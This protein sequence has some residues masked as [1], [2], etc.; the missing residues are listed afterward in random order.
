MSS[1]PERRAGPGSGQ[2]WPFGWLTG[3]A[4]VTDL[5]IVLGERNFRRL[6]A[7]RLISQTGDGIVTAGIGTYVFF[8]AETFTS[9]TAAAAALTVLYLPYSLVGPFAGVFIDR[10]SRRQILVWSALLRSVFV[11]LTA[12]LMA[13]GNRGVPGP[14]HDAQR[15]VEHISQQ[16]R[17]TA[18]QPLRPKDQPRQT[19]SFK[20]H[21]P[22]QFERS[23]RFEWK[24]SLR[25]ALLRN[26]RL[27]LHSRP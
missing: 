10:W 13:A 5:R 7:T 18:T 4:F 9:P 1:P 12:A 24:R 6:F 23:F 21:R 2:R 15:P 26:L 17:H 11:A 14:H 16:N 25:R 8:N 20:I 19:V 3:S 22:A 27:R